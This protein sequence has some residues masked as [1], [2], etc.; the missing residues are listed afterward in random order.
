MLINFCASNVLF[1]CLMSQAESKSSRFHIISLHS[2]TL[3]FKTYY[4]LPVNMWSKPF[5][6]KILR[7]I[8]SFHLTLDFLML[9]HIKAG[10]KTGQREV[11]RTDDLEKRYLRV[12]LRAN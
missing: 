2:I 10:K 3:N 11:I 1:S 9:C 7:Q 6:Q 4:F 8:V 5:E 12:M